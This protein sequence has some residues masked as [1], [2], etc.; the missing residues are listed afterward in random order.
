MTLHLR[1]TS[2]CQPLCMRTYHRANHIPLLELL[3]KMSTFLVSQRK[4]TSWNCVFVSWRWLWMIYPSRV[5]EQIKIILAM[6]SFFSHWQSGLERQASCDKSDMIYL[7]ESASQRG[8]IS[9][10]CIQISQLMVPQLRLY[11]KWPLLSSINLLTFTLNLHNV[12]PK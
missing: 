4:K 10:L 7:L 12:C 3:F 6:F 11:I 1:I 2:N 5:P 9:N 8:D